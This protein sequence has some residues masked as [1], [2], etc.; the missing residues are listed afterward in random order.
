MIEY[1]LPYS[2]L[3]KLIDKL[4]AHKE[5]EKGFDDGLKKLK[6]MMEK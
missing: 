3:G 1:E 4:S 5:L 2:F 6:D